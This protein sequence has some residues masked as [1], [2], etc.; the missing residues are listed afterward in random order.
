MAESFALLTLT[1]ALAAGCSGSSDADDGD[2]GAAASS[3]G[4]P[5]ASASTGD[6]ASGSGGSTSGSSG[7]TSGAGVT[8]GAGGAGS[9]TAGTGGGAAAGTGGSGEASSTTAGTGGGANPGSEL[10]NGAMEGSGKSSERYETGLVS[11]DGTP[12]VLITNGWGPGFGNHTVSWEGTSFTVESMSGSAGSMGQPASY[13]TVFCGRYSV[14]EVPDCGLPAPSSSI[15][16]LRTGWRWEKNGNEG[17]YNAAFDIWMGNGTQLQGYL[18]VWLRDP[19][20]FQPAGQPNAAHQGI[21]VANV[22]G[23]WNIWN[24]MV[25][26]LPIVNWVRAE[27]QDSSEIEF[28]VMDFVRDAQTRGISV[29]GNTVNAVAVGFEIWEG[30]ITNLKSLDFYVDVN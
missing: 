5:S 22:P 3:G 23:K 19:T 15:K 30:P 18:M 10:G 4:L 29:P 13:P 6:A 20:R 26:G 14:R 27:G 8:T 11:R 9:T 12:Y 1:A 2:P 21:E 24:G 28:D 17:Q 7:V 25:N 16:S